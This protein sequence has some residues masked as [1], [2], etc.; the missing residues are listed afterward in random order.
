MYVYNTL[1]NGKYK[2]VSN[3]KRDREDKKG[4]V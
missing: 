4:S 2:K 3:E 1:M